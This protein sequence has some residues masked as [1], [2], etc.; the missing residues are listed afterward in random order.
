MTSNPCWSVNLTLKIKDKLAKQPY[1]FIGQ[2][3]P[4]FNFILFIIYA[5]YKQI[6]N[7]PV[8]VASFLKF[9]DLN[10]DKFNELCNVFFVDNKVDIINWLIDNEQYQH[11]MELLN[12]FKSIIDLKQVTYYLITKIPFIN[13]L[14]LLWQHYNQNIVKSTYNHF[15]LYYL[16]NLGYF[17]FKE[18]QFVKN[19]P[20]ICLAFRLKL[21][22]QYNHSLQFLFKDNFNDLYVALNNLIPFNYTAE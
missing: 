8:S 10:Y 4:E 13:Q 20:E 15:I 11:L 9:I 2:D 3:K 1:K 7:Q 21:Q 12:A 14:F 5:C 17:G 6:S 16:V 18:L 19:E 22:A